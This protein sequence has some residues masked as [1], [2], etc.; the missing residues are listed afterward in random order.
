M[1]AIDTSLAMCS[2]ET[3][4]VRIIFC[5]IFRTPPPRGSRRCPSCSSLYYEDPE[6]C[7][8]VI[9][10]PSQLSPQPT[11]VA[12]IYLHSVSCIICRLLRNLIIRET[13]IREAIKVVPSSNGPCTATMVENVNKSLCLI[14]ERELHQFRVV[15]GTKPSRTNFL[16]H[17]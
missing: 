11:S 7:L 8:R 6:S 3:D 1:G 16:D 14:P 4:R 17:T 10:S 5:E 13:G 12:A 2:D 15:P 9:P